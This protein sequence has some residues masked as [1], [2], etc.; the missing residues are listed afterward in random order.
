SGLKAGMLADSSE[1]ESARLLATRTKAR[2]RTI[3]RLPTRR[4]WGARM[5]RRGALDSLG[6][7]RRSDLRV[8]AVRSPEP[9]SASCTR[10]GT[11]AKLLGPSRDAKK[12]RPMGGAA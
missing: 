4:V 2:T 7:G 9:L 3:S 10:S 5:P 1:V 12:A 11:V 8:V 6:G